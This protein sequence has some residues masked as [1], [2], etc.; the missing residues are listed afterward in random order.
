MGILL[1]AL[2]VAAV[3]LLPRLLS[4]QEDLPEGSS[5]TEPTSAASTSGETA[6]NDSIP[7]PN[8]QSELRLHFN[9]IQ[10]LNGVS[11][12]M[13]AEEVSP[14]LDFEHVVLPGKN[15]LLGEEESSILLAENAK[16]SV[17]G[18]PVSSIYFS[19]ED[20]LL[21]EVYVSFYQKDISYDKLV[22]LLS[23]RYGEPEVQSDNTHVWSGLSLTVFLTTQEDETESLVVYSYTNTRFGKL[24][25][26]GAGIDPGG[27]LGENTPIG[28][29]IDGY[30]EGLT[31]G[32]DYFPISDGSGTVTMYDMLPYFNYLGFDMTA[33]SITLRIDE[34]GI[35]N[36]AGYRISL[37][38]D[39]FQQKAVSIYHTLSQ[40]YGPAPIY[41][42]SVNSLSAEEFSSAL[43]EGLTDDSFCSWNVGDYTLSFFLYPGIADSD[44]SVFIAIH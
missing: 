4:P 18:A 3:F 20:L 17:L 12:G 30:L 27:F 2:A 15:N 37:D 7:D 36:L 25:F 24:E 19:F 10:E 42:D 23:S 29:S 31:E 28:Q 26:S 32:S 34:T 44:C 40:L 14:L 1:V 38:E 6:S 9:N 21:Q 22:K 13:T 16:A 11:L 41:G 43:N 33:L 35:I 8:L 39:S 5:S